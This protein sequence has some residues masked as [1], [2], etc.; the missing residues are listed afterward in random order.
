MDWC[1][2]CQSMLPTALLVL[3]SA[4]HLRAE[5]NTLP[6]VRYSFG[7][8]GVVRA[9]FVEGPFEQSTDSF[10]KA[11]APAPRS[12]ASRGA[13]LFANKS[14]VL[15]FNTQFKLPSG[16]R[17]RLAAKGSVQ[18]STDVQGW[19]LLRAEGGLDVTI[20]GKRQY[21]RTIPFAHARGWEA[22]PVQLTAGIHQLRLEC[23]RYSEHW[24]L[25]AR[26][27]DKSG[28]A[29]ARSAWLLPPRRGANAGSIEPFEVSIDLTATAPV[30]LR[31]KVDAPLGTPV[32][33][34]EPLIL[35]LHAPDDTEGRTYALGTWPSDTATISPLYVQLGLLEELIRIFPNQETTLFLDASVGPFRVRRRLYLSQEML[36]VWQR[37]AQQLSALPSQA[38]VPLDVVRTSLQMAQNGLT[39]VAT[40]E[41][42][43]TEKRRAI[44]LAESIS[45]AIAEG[46]MPWTEPGVHDLAWR[47]TADGSIQ[48]FALQVPSHVDQG[49]GFPL[50][51]V[52]HGYNGTPRR[53]LDA[54]LD[55][56]P[57]K[58]LNHVNGFVLAPAAHGNAFYRGPGERDVL[59]LLNWALKSLPVDPSKV[60][61]TGASMGG[62]GTAEI[63]LHYPDRFAAQA[64]LCGY[65]SYYV[66]RDT[67][68][69]PLRA[70]ER[71][72]MHRFS[73]ASSADSGRHLPMHLAHGLKDRP[74]ENSRV[75]TSRY[76]KL[77][78]RLIEDWPDL[79]HAVWKK[80]WAHA[81]LFPWLSNQV[82]VTDPPRITLAATSLRHAQNYWLKV[83]EMDSQAELSTIDAE[84]S[85]PNDVHV[86]TEGVTGFAIKETTHIDAKR[87]LQLDIDGNRLTAAAN[88]SLRFYRRDSKWVQCAA[89]AGLHKGPSAEGPWLDLWSERLIFV[90]GSGKPD[91]I[92]TNLNVARALASPQGGADYDYPVVSDREFMSTR[93]D[94]VVP[95]LIGNS[96][97]NLLLAHYAAQLPV[98]VG[99]KTI[100]V[101]G[102]T[103]SGERLGALYVYPDPDDPSRIVGVITAPEPSGIWQALSLPSLLPDFIVYD[104]QVTPAAGEIILGRRGRVLAAGYFNNDWSLPARLN[105]DIDEMQKPLPKP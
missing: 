85:A 41:K 33:A 31:V 68:G 2:L 44:M 7:E 28:H 72:L 17:E 1:R 79:G 75:L 29:P 48:N 93:K 90:Y 80:T 32:P 92:G 24:S 34:G 69:Q 53:I 70:W 55:A 89:P 64:P 95:I 54:F 14:G 10:E 25:A 104:S 26:F 49:A 66:R 38:P 57:G 27:I 39:E 60:T 99:E 8:S 100:L 23:L 51:L 98:K 82:R 56:E 87:P 35:K 88:S 65:Q 6:D 78:Y 13:V 105:D 73:A 11:V 12:P 61:I 43:A 76:K 21:R 15:D 37:I 102:H 71:K 3:S 20:D 86:V 74:L 50:V 30:G 45:L 67:S 22:L 63:A 47:A 16:K 9:W 62:T 94:D 19:L 103:Y 59:E 97:D 81:G 5:S 101:G 91:T 40:Q 36:K 46:K 18:V 84:I 4:A 96:S 52:L 58:P 77:G 83:V 42:S